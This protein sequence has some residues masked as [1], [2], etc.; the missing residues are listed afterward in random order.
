M[1][2]AGILGDQ[3]A[4]LVGQACFAPGEAKNTYGTGCFMLMNTGETAPSPSSCGLLTTVGYQFGDERAGLRARRLDRRHR[5]AGA[6]AARQPR[7][8]RQRA[9]RSRRWRAR[10]ADN[11]GV[12]FVPAFSGLY[13]PY[14]TSGARGVVAGLTRYANKGH[15]ARAALEATAY[16]TRDVLDA[17][18]EDSGIALEALRVDGGMA[19]T[20]C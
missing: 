9:P 2:I 19:S 16:Q 3:Q 6:V 17:M 5:R 15:I 11:G 1:P 8:D 10:C 13:A 12:Y 7:P 4:A 18:D 20:T 14:W